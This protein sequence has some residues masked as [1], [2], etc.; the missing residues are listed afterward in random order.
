MFQKILIANDGSEEAN[1]AFEKAIEIAKETQADLH[2]IVVEEFPIYGDVEAATMVFD[3]LH[4]FYT[5]TVQKC[6]AIAKASNVNF[7]PHIIRG[8][9][10]TTI[11]DFTKQNNFDLLVIGFMEHCAIYRWLI[12]S[13]T[14]GLVNWVPC[15][16]LVVK[17]PSIEI[18]E[19]Q[20]DG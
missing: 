10:V 12:G 8:F 13:T 18:T 7:T 3:D 17:N 9:P 1:L 4:D 5:M 6:V 16:I 14:D 19:E 15:N 2:M 11:S 20:I